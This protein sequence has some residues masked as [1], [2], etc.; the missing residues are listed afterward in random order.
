MASDQIYV[1]DL[2]RVAAGADERIG[3]EIRLNEISFRETDVYPV[4]PPLHE[5]LELATAL[6]RAGVGQIQIRTRDAAEIVP[7]VRGAGLGLLVQAICRPYFHQPYPDW[8]SEIRAAAD[9]GVD[10]ILI[11]QGISRG[12]IA[13]EPIDEEAVLRGIGTWIEFGRSVG[14]PHVNLGLAD[15]SR[16]DFGYF[17]R[18]VRTGEDAG[19]SLIHLANSMGVLRPASMQYLVRHVQTWT[20]LPLGVHC[21]NSFGLA[22][23]NALAAAEVG[24]FEFDIGVNGQDPPKGLPALD[25]FALALLALYDRDIGVDTAR[26]Y[27]VARLH[28]RCF[29]VPVPPYKPIV[30][31]RAFAKQRELSIRG[32]L[33]DPS[34]F[35]PF[36]PELVG[37]RPRVSMGAGVGPTA[38]RVKLEELGLSVSIESVDRVVHAIRERAEAKRDLVNDDEVRG[39]VART[40]AEGQASVLPGGS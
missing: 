9:A 7:A 24:V 37:N 15:C 33:M 17:E 2:H 3:D 13:N 12:R 26:L 21:H 32:V 10:S 6:D 31:E 5:K 30:G 19:A 28:A 25:E 34:V 11:M 39:I 14:V 23:A 1:G 29:G 4:S 35:E 38:V 16:A 22:L 8:Q 40:E 36:D 20:S 27:E 18:V